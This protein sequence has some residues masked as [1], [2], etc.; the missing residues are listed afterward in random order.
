M[1]KSQP[2]KIKPELFELTKGRTPIYTSEN[3][4][5]R[6]YP[7]TKEEE[8]AFTAKNQFYTIGILDTEMVMLVEEGYYEVAKPLFVDETFENQRKA[9][10]TA[11]DFY[12]KI[13]FFPFISLLVAVGAFLIFYFIFQPS[14]S[15]STNGLIAGLVGYFASTIVI[16][17]WK[18]KQ[19]N[20]ITAERTKAYFKTLGG[21]DKAR[22]LDNKINAYQTDYLHKTIKLPD[23]EP[24]LLDE[25][26]KMKAKKNKITPE[27]QAA[28]DKRAKALSQLEEPSSTEDNNSSTDDRLKLSADH[29]AQH[30]EEAKQVV[31]SV[32]DSYSNPKTQASDVV[33]EE[34]KPISLDS[35]TAK[36]DPSDEDDEEEE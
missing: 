3:G 31:P 15:A 33:F 34:Y 25:V 4:K 35:T 12:L 17:F 24:E 26:T 1:A 36:V 28:L 10:L 20:K 23:I 32:L 6:I 14:D 8:Q 9:V 27:E 21:E 22:I 2:L 18:R 29:Q 7:F 5:Y 16:S 13:R 30:D 19:T 11:Q